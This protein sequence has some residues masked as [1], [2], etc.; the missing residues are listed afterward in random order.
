MISGHPRTHIVELIKLK[1]AIMIVVKLFDE[2]RCRNTELV[3]MFGEVD[4]M[5]ATTT[6]TVIKLRYLGGC[7]L[8][9]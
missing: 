4:Q 3:D 6:I 5:I 7:P 2:R 1:F 8:Y 9:V